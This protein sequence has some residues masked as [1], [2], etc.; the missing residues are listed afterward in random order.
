MFINIHLYLT[1][2]IIVVSV[3]PLITSASIVTIFEINIFVL[4]HDFVPTDN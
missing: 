3:R 2:Y 1:P 4:I